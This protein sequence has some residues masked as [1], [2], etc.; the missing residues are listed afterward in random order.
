MGAASKGFDGF[1]LALRVLINCNF[2]LH[3]LNWRVLN[4]SGNWNNS[5]L[6]GP[7]NL[8]AN[9]SSA[10]TNLNNGCHQLCA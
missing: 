10:N 1:D 4:G 6:N 8:N 2:G 9:N 3:Q 5:G 7:W